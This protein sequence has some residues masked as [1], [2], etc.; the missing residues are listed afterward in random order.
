MCGGAIGASVATL[1]R[2]QVDGFLI[3]KNPLAIMAEGNVSLGERTRPYYMG[4]R[5]GGS[6]LLGRRG[7]PPSEKAALQIQRG[8]A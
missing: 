3:L 8:T 6:N 4:Y 5:I 7:I 2:A 1:R